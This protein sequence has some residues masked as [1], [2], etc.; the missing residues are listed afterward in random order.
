MVVPIKLIKTSY[1][2]FT[3]FKTIHFDSLYYYRKDSN[4]AILF[5]LYGW[6]SNKFCC[7]LTFIV[8]D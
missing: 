7:E 1:L 4:N 5:N 3:C 6:S 2:H 8:N